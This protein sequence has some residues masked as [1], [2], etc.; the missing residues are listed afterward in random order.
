MSNDQFEPAPAHDFHWDRF[1]PDPQSPYP[2][3]AQQAIFLARF[4]QQRASQLQTP[5]ERRQQAELDRMIQSPH[6]KATLVQLTDQAFR[7]TAAPRA[8]DQLIHILDVQGIPRFFS[9]LEQALLRGFQSFG[10]YL[11]GVAVPLVKDKMQR[12]TANVILPAEREMLAEYLEQRGQEG[13]RMNVNFLG[14]ALLGEEEAA[15]RLEKYL[16]ALQWPEIEVISVK[17][18][19]LDSQITPLGREAASRRLCDRLELLYRAAAKQP[20]QSASG[21]STS[22]LV[23]LD[24]EEYR[25]ML[26]TADVF[27]RTLDRPGLENCNAG[28]ALQAYLPDS[29]QTQH[30]ILSWAR[31]RVAAGGAPVTMRLVKGANMETERME[32]SLRN[33]PQAP[34]KTKLQTDANYKKMLQLGLQPENIAAVRLGVASH[35][36][37]DVSYA[38]VLAGEQGCMDAVQFEMLEGMANHQRRAL[39]ELVDNMLLY[40][41][42]CAQDE[43][44]HAIGYLV[45]RMDE[46]SGPQN[47]LRHTFR[48]EV[49]SDAWQDLEN[50]FLESLGEVNKVSNQ[51]RRQQDRGAATPDPDSEQE[52]DNEPD[53]DFCLPANEEWIRQELESWQPP[54]DAIPLVIGNREVDQRTLRISTDPSRPGL[55][56][57]SF[58]EAQEEDV[59]EAVRCARE[60]P[61]GWRQLAA[62]ER[63][64]ILARVAGEIRRARAELI[65]LA[66]AEGGKTVSE[67][68]PEVSEAVDF[69]EFYRRSA[70]RLSEIESVEARGLGC[71][72]VASPWNFP[73]AIPAGGVAA[74]LAAGNTVI[75]KPASDTVLTAHR[76]CRCFW[77][78]GVPRESLQLLPGPGGSVGQ[79]LAT[80]PDV[81][82]VIL[83]GGTETARQILRENPQ[84]HL[85]AETGGK[86]TTI[87]TAMADRDLAIKH[88]LHS[89]FGHAGQ[90]C[91]ATSLLI[92]EREVYEDESFR[93]TLRDA[94][95]S[96]VVGSAWNLETRM[97][98][99]IRPPGDPL[100]SALKELEAGESWLLMP[101]VLEDNPCLVSPAIKWNVQPGS[102]THMTEFFGPLLGVLSAESL[103]EAIE[104]ANATGY[105]LTAGLESLD[106]REQEFWR[107]HIQAGNLY[108]N[109]PTT[110]AIVLRQPFG[111]FGKSAFGPGIKAG[112]PNYVRQ[113]MQ[114]K[115]AKASPPESDRE[116]L[117]NPALEGLMEDLLVS[118]PGDL[119]REERD[120]LLAALVSYDAWAEREFLTWHD[121]F[122]LCG[123]DNYR[124]YLAISQLRIRIVEG[125]TPFDVIARAAAARSVGSR[126][127]L[128][129]APGYPSALVGWLDR[130]T[131][132]WA[133]AIEF[134]EETDEQL[135]DAIRAGQV[136]RIRFSHPGQVPLAIRTMVASTGIELA[137][138]P[139]IEHGRLELPWYVQEQSISHDYHR[140]GNL[141]RRAA[142]SRREPD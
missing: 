92:L 71:I 115:A 99:L 29:L 56:V 106:E 96:L 66:L 33:W 61:A 9:R 31:Q 135:A 93:E 82:T 85:L 38:I 26:I 53:T 23:Y 64:E 72:V 59:L 131:D 129:L 49:D 87:V 50:Q 57:G 69:V 21:S 2:V 139:V 97:G 77:E 123:Q 101:Q 76:L 109:R 78:A 141:G 119:D 116:M 58:S 134:I 114:F 100:E 19:T 105:G 133:G 75:L 108:I 60:D 137:F 126:A 80:D 1:Q 34:Y 91:S 95:E 127:T 42:A 15:R 13:V 44:L 110:G 6:D 63:S 3:A 11:P 103:A 16:E 43:F 62:P 52:F 46:N 112:G 22:K 142:E 74:A 37:F 121:H 125:D 48:L 17:I 89:A 20:F 12:E 113:L 84:V 130:Q 83:T 14:E 36:L 79:R 4:L 54:A 138:H 55:Q 45:R 107:D 39:C 7:S 104:L 117:Q 111:G 25:D 40:A 67:A 68:D 73:I 27:M 118:P 30:K 90:K 24:M 41:P 65:M 28:I 124:R 51:P 136:D 81:D 86:N 140:Y 5:Q 32:A 35:N 132:S 128:S 8:A 94:A 70:V 98:P 120:R 88:V 122:Q 10:G 47:Y 102:V 18:S